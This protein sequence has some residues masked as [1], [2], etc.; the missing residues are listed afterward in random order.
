MSHAVAIG[1][2]LALRAVGGLQEIIAA[3]LPHGGQPSQ[4]HKGGAEPDMPKR[5]ATVL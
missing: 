2:S 3:G 4:K 1:N 5:H